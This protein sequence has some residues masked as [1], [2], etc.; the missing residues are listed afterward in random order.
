MLASTKRCSSCSRCGSR[1]LDL[2]SSQWLL[3]ESST[4]HWFCDKADD[5][6]RD[7]ATFL[8]RLICY[9]SNDF[10][11]P[12]KKALYRQLNECCGCAERFHDAKDVHLDQCAV[13]PHFR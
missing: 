8:L 10:I 1:A 9:K 12:F 5:L 7:A 4:A 13:R 2:T 11:D 3:D 6:H